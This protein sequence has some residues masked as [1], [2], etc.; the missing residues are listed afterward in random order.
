MRTVFFGT[1]R[2]AVPSLEA[3]ARHHEVIALVC[4]P[5][6]PQGRSARPV[7]PPTK[8]WA[9]EH[10]VPVAQP[11]K[12]NDGTFEAWLRSQRADIC[13]LAAY[14]RILKQAIL[15]VPP[16][17]FLN[18]HPSL[19]PLYRGPSPIQSVILNGE[20]ETG[21]TIMRITLEMDSG[22]ILLQERMPIAPEDNAQTLTER[23]AAR[24]GEMLAE[25]VSLVEEGKAVFTPQDH[26]RATYCSLFEKR[27]GR[28]D[29]TRP[30]DSI[31]NL[32]RAA[33]PWPGAQC[34][35]RGEV[36]RI[37]ESL[38]LD[39]AGQGEPG[40]VTHV[41]K[42]R[43]LVATGAGSL[44]VLAFQ[45]PGKKSLPMSDYLRGHQIAVGDRFETIP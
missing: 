3:L 19:L 39:L 29:W 45:A 40:T 2:L 28:I 25:G 13:V 32:V 8:V 14:G 41:E 26:A 12:L 30:A 22:D 24:G 43:V 21:V 31:H 9:V 37:H 1:P 10:G 34:L 16:H 20:T 18:M 11:V 6:R 15:D 7:P 4:Q 35:Y 23:L 38:P 33:N 36:C 17:G 5:D 42:D 27:D 44:A